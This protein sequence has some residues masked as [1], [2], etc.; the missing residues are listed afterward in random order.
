MAGV[1]QYRQ[2]TLSTYRV[3]FP[4]PLSTD[5][6]SLP[7]VFIMKDKGHIK[8]RYCDVK[9]AEMSPEVGKLGFKSPF[10]K[11]LSAVWPAARGER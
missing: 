1:K 4:H 7:H 3:P 10:S 5:G 6:V 8:K 9:A 2:R 11:R